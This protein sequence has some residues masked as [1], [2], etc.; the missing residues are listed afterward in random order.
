MLCLVFA[1]QTKNYQANTKFAIVYANEIN[2]QSE[3]NLRS[4]TVFKLHEGTK[5]QVMDVVEDWKQIKLT[6]GKTG[7]IPRKVLKEI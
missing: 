6:D 7:W 2:I 1:F 3:P 4:E 5:V